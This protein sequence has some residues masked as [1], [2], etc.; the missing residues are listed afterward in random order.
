MTR[1]ADGQMELYNWGENLIP[2]CFFFFS[3][4][5]LL[6]EVQTCNCWSE[7]IPQVKE[8]DVAA[9]YCGAV[10]W[11]GHTWPTWMWS[12]CC[13]ALW[14]KQ[15]LKQ[16]HRKILNIQLLY[17]QTSCVCPACQWQA[18]AEASFPVASE[19]GWDIA[20]FVKFGHHW[21]WPSIIGSEHCLFCSGKC[22][23]HIPCTVVN[24]STVSLNKWSLIE[25]YL[26]SGQKSQESTFC[27]I[28]R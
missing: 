12:I 2:N 22:H 28:G 21:G 15:T 4:Q 25:T 18:S 13:T 26:D 17:T 1:Y 9:L 19:V 6:T 3:F 7:A 27:T 20:A 10:W 23:C 5:V 24:G 14:R 8:P 16:P 11:S